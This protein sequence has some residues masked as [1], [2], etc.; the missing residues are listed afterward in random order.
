MLSNDYECEGQINMFGPE[1]VNPARLED[2]TNLEFMRTLNAE[3]LEHFIFEKTDYM[4]LQRRGPLSK[5]I[6]EL[7]C[8][9]GKYGDI[10]GCKKCRIDWLNSKIG[11]REK[12][13][14]E[15][16]VKR[17]EEINLLKGIREKINSLI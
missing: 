8:R 4:C 17:K 2:M 6:W 16:A 11:S 15:Q 3:D 1:K 7:N 13:L 10:D 12:E 9:S 14:H 5:E